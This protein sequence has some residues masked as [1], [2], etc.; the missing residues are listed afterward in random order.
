MLLYLKS[1]NYFKI[2]PIFELPILVN[3][4]K[5]RDI[6]GIAEDN[7]KN[8]NIGNLISKQF[9]KI[10]EMSILETL[11]FLIIKKAIVGPIEN[12]GNS[13][14]WEFWE[15]Y[16]PNCKKWQFLAICR[17]RVGNTVHHLRRTS[18]ASETCLCYS[19]FRAK[20]VAPVKKA[21]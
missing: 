19:V 8:E 1:C 21:K 12:S 2:W 18:T 4:V 16:G 7:G 3:F 6:L 15:L 13:K 9:S 10:C 20:W 14:F 5:T 17:A 11:P